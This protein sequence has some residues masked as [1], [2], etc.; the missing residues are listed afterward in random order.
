MDK[1]R[2]Y[3]KPRKGK[4]KR[5]KDEEVNGRGGKR[6]VP[7]PHMG[8]MAQGWCLMLYRNNLHTHYFKNDT[9]LMKQNYLV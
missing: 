2:K 5:G 4:E 1:R 8:E 9:P 7:R 3:V 6:G